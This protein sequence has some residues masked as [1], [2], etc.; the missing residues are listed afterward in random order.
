M[1]NSLLYKLIA[2]F[3][4]VFFCA[5]G[6]LTYF[7]YTS[8]RDAMLQEFKIRGRSLAK[9][10][11]S[12]SSTYYHTR[13]V[14]GFTTLL[15][16]L[17]E[18]EDV[19]AILTYRSPKTL[20]IEFAGIE[21]TAEDLSLQETTDAW[22]YDEVLS[23]GHVVS[24]FGNAVVGSTHPS[25]GGGQG[26]VPP[27][28]WIRVFLDRQALEKRLD[29]LVIRTLLISGLTI[30]L[31]GIVFTWLLRQSLHVIGPL[32][33]ATK[34]V[35]QGDLRT[36]VPVSSHDEL[37][38]LAQGFNSMTEQLL[39]TTVSKNYVD[40]IIRSMIDTLIV[41][42]PDGTI[43]S[44]NQ[45]SLQLLGYEEQ[46]LLGQPITILFPQR[47]GVFSG[48]TSGE[49]LQQSVSGHRET[50]CRTKDGRAIPMLLS[51]AVMRDERNNVQGIICVGKDMTEI[52]QAEQQLLLH[53]TALE[54]AANAVV[55]TDREGRITWA[56]PSFTSLT[57]YSL[58]EAIG[59]D[60]RMLKSGQHDQAFDQNQWNTILSGKVWRGE[61]VNRKKNGSL[62]TEEVTITPVHDQNGEIS[63]FIRIKQDV[64]ER[65]QAEKALIA[66]REYNRTLFELSPIGLALFEMSGTIVDCN[67]TYAAIVGRPR[68]EVL[69]MTYWEL[70]PTAY[71]EQARNIMDAIM[72]TGYFEHY[73]KHYIHR[74]GHLV[75]VRLFGNLIER[76][77]ELYIFCSVEDITERRKGE[78]ALKAAHQKLTE[79]N[80]TRSE[81]LANISHELRTPLTVIRGEAEVTIRGKDKPIVEY[82]AALE[83]IV[84][85]T[86]QVNQ[87]VGDLLFISRSESGTI[88]IDKQPTP[89]LEILLAMHQE[90]RVLAEKKHIAVTLTRQN[91]TPIIV[92]GDA[93]R[94]RQLFMIIITNAINYTKPEGAITVN[95]DSDGISTR[96]TVADNGIGIPEED[97]PHVFQRFYRVKQGRQDLARSGSGLGLPIAKWIA[98]AHNG[99]ISIASVLG[100]GTTVTIELPLHRPR[101]P[102]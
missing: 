32:T 48:I 78:E 44:L 81:F 61:I 92:N 35:A 52:Q 11:A 65:K 7:T 36:I 83:R 79:L 69:G 72:K 53:E 100:Q 12:E 46:E 8:S 54:S 40:N 21:L 41:V 76:D 10:I 17:G 57:G 99:T 87:L 63:H 84:Q 34:K 64:T 47:Q 94:L 55:I 39:T 58:E 1:K 18:T 38:E 43:Q 91:D 9:A 59:Q 5:I 86:N 101:A 88:E 4:V 3:F 62:Y 6:G 24:E 26:A 97:L 68:S 60:V 13:D 85:L 95:L 56:N 82:K 80:E 45:A 31:G 20:W 70:T 16:S 96:I 42:S 15:Q 37:G 67:E 75:P 30:L 29:T 14:E 98:E 2:L 49:I 77:N 71:D 23:R 50:T 25:L 28:G 74:D 51:E 89:L 66:S 90:A 73:E 27:L 22:Q 19:L 33:A 102:R 93:Q